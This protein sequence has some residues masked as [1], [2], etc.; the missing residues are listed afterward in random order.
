MNIL[1]DLASRNLLLFEGVRA[2][3]RQRCGVKVYF[4]SLIWNPD[5]CSLERVTKAVCERNV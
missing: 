2:L 5:N 3:L 1:D 4:V